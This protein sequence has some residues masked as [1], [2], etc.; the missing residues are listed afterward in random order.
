MSELPN[1][2]MWWKAITFNQSAI[3]DGDGGDIISPPNMG[4]QLRDVVVWLKVRKDIEY[5]VL[6][7]K[8][9]VLKINKRYRKV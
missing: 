3:V 5:R 4:C 7:L 1:G 6:I 2:G 9:Y 8:I